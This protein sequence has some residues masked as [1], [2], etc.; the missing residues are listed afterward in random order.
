MI[1]SRAATSI[2]GRLAATEDL[3]LPIRPD[4]EQHRD[5]IGPTM[6]PRDRGDFD[7]SRPCIEYYRSQRELLLM[8]PIKLLSLR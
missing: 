5:E 8:V 2:V 3:P 1:S 7:P 4:W 6:P